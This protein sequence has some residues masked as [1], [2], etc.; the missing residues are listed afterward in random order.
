MALT[1]KIKKMIKDQVLLSHKLAKK[2]KDG[3]WGRDLRKREEG[4]P[5]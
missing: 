1:G 5:A 2:K 3:R 4:F